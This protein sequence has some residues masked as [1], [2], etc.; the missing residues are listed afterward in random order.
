MVT[1]SHLKKFASGQRRRLRSGS[2]KSSYDSRRVFAVG[3]LHVCSALPEY[4]PS[5]DVFGACAHLQPPPRLPSPPVRRATLN[6][7]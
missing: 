6:L 4:T 7:I 1:S 5:H 2:A 3:P